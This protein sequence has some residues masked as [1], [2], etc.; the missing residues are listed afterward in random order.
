MR[1]SVGRGTDAHYARRAEWATSL[2][3]PLTVARGVRRQCRDKQRR[4]HEGQAREA[5]DT[6]TAP[7]G[8]SRADREGL[9][10]TPLRGPGLR[11]R[12]VG[13]LVARGACRAGLRPPAP[14][15]ASRPGRAGA[16]RCRSVA[17]RDHGEPQR[18]R[19][20]L[21][22]RLAVGGEREHR[23]EQLLE[24]ESGADDADEVELVV[25]GVP[26]LVRVPGSTVRTSP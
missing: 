5:P 13:R 6:R 8:P 15:A 4:V 26:E 9:A 10:I 3:R 1:T 25:A 17:L 16:G 23:L 20:A 2:T 19:H 7:E 14:S 21:P 24:L 18:V 22:V 12:H 11:R